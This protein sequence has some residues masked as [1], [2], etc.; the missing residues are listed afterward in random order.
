MK[1]PKNDKEL[2]RQRLIALSIVGPLP[3]IM[4]IIIAILYKGNTFAL[5]ICILG[6]IGFVIMYTFMILRFRSVLENRVE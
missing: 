6:S 2:I 1:Y 3:I 4:L 5:I